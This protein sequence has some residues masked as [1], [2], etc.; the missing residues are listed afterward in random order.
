MAQSDAIKKYIRLRNE[1]FR[2]RERLGVQAS[3]EEDPILDEMDPLWYSFTEEEMKIAR[4]LPKC[5]I[6]E[7]ENEN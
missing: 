1:V 5:V 7:E 3:D 2:I 4:K 6:Q